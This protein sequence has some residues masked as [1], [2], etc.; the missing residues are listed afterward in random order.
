MSKIEEMLKNEKVEWKEIGDIPEIKVITVKKK[1]KKQ[2]YLREGD[3]PIIDQGQEFIV[4]YTND[5]D[6]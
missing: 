2:E 5:N 3:Y 4:G 1:L 6:A